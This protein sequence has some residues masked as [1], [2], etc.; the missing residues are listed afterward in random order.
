MYLFI[1]AHPDDETVGC[2]GTIAQLRAA[3]E[4]VYLFTVTDGAG[5]EVLPVAQA[6]LRSCD[7]NIGQLRMDELYAAA[8]LLGVERD[9]V[10]CLGFPDGQITNQ[11]VWGK[12][13]EAITGV[14]NEL[15][16]EVV[17]T[18]DHSGWYYHLDHVATSI[19]TTMALFSVQHP[20]T[21]AFHAHYW[22]PG[23][24]WRYAWPST[25]PIT[26]TVDI[27]AVVD[28]KKRAMDCHASQTLVDPARQLAMPEGKTETYQLIWQTE[29]AHHWWQ[30]QKI[31][32]AY[33]EDIM[34]RNGHQRML[35][36]ETESA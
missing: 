1:F 23:T 11:D 36:P 7:G 29:N 35:S 27:Q 9:H 31:F 33:T 5:G 13:A 22:V 32:T 12:L 28:Q 25:M 19:A 15:K 21:V 8:A 18:F 16:P 2:G 26:H 20:P 34:F 4:E 10:G 14:L 30:K 6:Q 3:G 24:K 17:V